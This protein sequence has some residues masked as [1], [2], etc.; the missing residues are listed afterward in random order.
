MAGHHFVA[1][2]G[3][4]WAQIGG[5]N[6][7]PVYLGC[8]EIG[9]IDE[10]QGDIELIYCPDPSGPSRFQVVN[11]LQGAAGAITT[12]I[13]TDVTD[14]LDY[15]ERAR[16]PFPIYISMVKAG[17][18]NVFTNYDR[19]FVLT[20]ARVTSRG[21]T[22]LTT[23]TPD[24]NA[25][26]EMTFDL[27]GETLIRAA[28]LEPSRQS[29]TETQ[30]ITDLAFCNAE[31]CATDTEP[32][33]S[34]GQIGFA[35][36]EAG[37][38]VTANVLYTSN[39]A[40]W[41]ATGADPFAADVNLGG[42]ECF[43]M[44]RNATRVIV[45]R[46]ETVVATAA[47]VSYSDDLGATWTSVAI[48]AANAEFIKPQGLVALDRSNIWVATS[49]GKIYKSSDGAVTW[50][51]QEASVIHSGAYNSIDFADAEV[52]WAAGAANVVARTIDGGTSWSSVGGATGKAA[53]AIN[54][55]HA[56]D[57][58]RA[59]IGYAD[60]TLYYTSDGGTT[61]SQRGHTD[62][63]VGQV[64]DIDFVDDYVGILTRNNA[65]P[66]GRILY[67]LDGGFT[68]EPL[69]TPTNAGISVAKALDYWTFYVAGAASG[70]TGYIAK[71]TV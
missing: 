64:T 40:T 70:G 25:R 24:D 34:V 65:S 46:G 41:T 39:G 66:A 5:P 7:Q 1:G 54:T 8:H 67:T 30:S 16:C 19:M 6:S 36:T 68:W 10:P 63:G 33:L 60:G 35:V 52:G 50:T 12:T 20:N 9:D 71:A 31:Q 48:G 43:E 15:L 4:L 38:G 22:G 42:V 18:K 58:N 28:R 51:L 13:T 29:I 26:S 61:W 21:L 44:G 62:S 3:A 11:S 14:D 27:S 45:S 53:V 17:L 32:A 49:G 2:E 69:T 56:V 47:A 37:T 23:R 59:W 57:R 55:I